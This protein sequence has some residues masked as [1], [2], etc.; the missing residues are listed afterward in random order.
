MTTG[1]V[2]LAARR[3]VA[4]A[5]VVAVMLAALLALLTTPLTAAGVVPTAWTVT[6]T[7]LTLTEGQAADVTL[8]VTGGT[9]RIRCLLV[10]VPADFTVLDANVAS[11]PAG[12]TWNA[13][14]S[15]IAPT[16]VT[17][18]LRSGGGGIQLLQAADLEVQVMPMTAIASAWTTSGHTGKSCTSPDVGPPLLPLQPF[19]IIPGPTPTATPTP[20]PTDT[21]TATPTP[22]PTATSTATPTPSPTATSTATPTAARS[23]S[24]T[25]TPVPTATRSQP[26]TPTAT[27]AASPAPSATIQPAATPSPSS[28][29]A[30]GAVAGTTGGEGPN[31]AGISVADPRADAQVSA[32]ELGSIDA[33]G[34]AWLV[35]GALLGLPGLLLLLIIGTQ[36]GLASL[37]VTLT[38]RAMPEQEAAPIG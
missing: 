26:A 21:S 32:G 38:G 10:S 36:A 15:A 23:P 11:V 16:Q 30:G 1:S 25:P 3:R 8:A 27:A 17:F 12:E 20:T 34:Y 33:M 2:M 24:P 28:N 13:S 6:A 22:S 35:P 7:P 29:V 31:D 4:A 14:F 9:T 5:A 18:S 19:V 37:F